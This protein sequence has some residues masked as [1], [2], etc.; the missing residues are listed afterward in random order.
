MVPV[1]VDCSP[2]MRLATYM[3]EHGLD[4]RA[5]AALVV[6]RVGGNC[7]R[8]AIRK[9]RLGMGRPSIDRAYEIEKATEGAVSLADWQ[10]E[11]RNSAAAAARRAGEC[12]V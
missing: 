3:L 10:Y 8:H 5:M 6:E 12:S 7:S 1:R 9:L 2:A 4:D 11:A